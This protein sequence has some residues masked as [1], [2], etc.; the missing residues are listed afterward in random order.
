MCATMK[1]C[2]WTPYLLRK[3][4]LKVFV[5][6]NQNLKFLSE[7]DIL[8]WSRGSVSVTILWVIRVT[9]PV[10]EFVV[11]W[12][13][14]RMPVFWNSSLWIFRAG[15][16]GPSCLGQGKNC[17]S[18]IGKMKIGRL[19]YFETVNLELCLFA[20]TRL[21]CLSVNKIYS[22]LAIYRPWSV[23]AISPNESVHYQTVFI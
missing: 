14:S 12:S 15:A 7:N 20:L 21:A 22:I 19:G 18:V 13:L 17:F 9:L 3:E 8:F 4:I 5:C 2:S 1:W 6:F 10:P 16:G 11:H 23:L